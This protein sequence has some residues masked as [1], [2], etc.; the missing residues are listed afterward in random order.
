MALFCEYA[1]GSFNVWGYLLWSCA[2][3]FS[4]VAEG[5]TPWHGANNNDY[6]RQ[7]CHSYA[8][9]AFLGIETEHTTQTPHSIKPTLSRDL[10]Q[11]T[12]RYAQGL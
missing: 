1:V 11:L 12:R 5:C 8:I 3:I 6:P 4:V 9:G 2:E 7:Q 10:S